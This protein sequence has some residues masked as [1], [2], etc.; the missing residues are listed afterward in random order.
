MRPSDIEI[1]ILIWNIKIIWVGNTWKE[2]N[3]R[4]SRVK[5]RWKTKEAAIQI[6]IRT[7]NKQLR[8]EHLIM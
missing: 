8:E 1:G 3:R 4:R 2:A 5:N 6:P 7:N